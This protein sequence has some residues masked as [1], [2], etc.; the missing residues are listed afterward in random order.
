MTGALDRRRDNGA[1]EVGEVG[2][3]RLGPPSSAMRLNICCPC[4]VIAM[5]GPPVRSQGYR[6]EF[7][8]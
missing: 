4:Q 5:K 6:R 7:Q 3:R 2:S 1:V 8:A